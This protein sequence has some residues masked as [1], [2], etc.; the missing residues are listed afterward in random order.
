MKILLIHVS[1]NWGGRVYSEYPLGL[2]MIGTICHNAG[3]DVRLFDM[4]VEDKEIQD[5][6][7]SYKPDMIGLSF[8]STSSVTAFGLI[9]EIRKHVSV[10][11]IAVYA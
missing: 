11:I 4:A 7:A 6:I 9:R 2:G 10:P 3:Y 1:K 5:E 8:L